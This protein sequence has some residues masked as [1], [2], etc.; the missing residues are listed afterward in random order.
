[1]KNLYS[2]ELAKS[3]YDAI[4]IGSGLGGLTTAVCLSKAGKKVLVLEK[5]YVPGGFTHTFK[6]KKYEWD[7]GVHYVGQVNIKNN[8]LCKAFDYLTEGKLKWADMGDVYDQTIIDGDT[9]NFK[10]GRKNQID[11]MI[12]YFPKEEKAIVAYY[13]LVEKIGANYIMFFS[14][15]TMPLWLSK[16]VGYFLR[17]KFYKYSQQTTYKILSNLTSNEK[18]IAV[19][20][21]QCGNYGLAPKQS[22]FAIH[23]MIVEHFLEGGNYPVGGASSIHKSLI[24]VI[25]S[26]GGKIAIKAE[27]KNIMIENN[28][29]IGVEMKN[30][31]KL[32]ASSIVS[33]AGAHNTFNTL[34]SKSIQKNENTTELNKIKPSVSHVCIYVGLNASD[35]E[36]KLPKHN[37]WI[38]DS[39][40]LDKTH[41][42]HLEISESVSPL[43]YIS[44]PSA[45]DPDWKIKHPGMSTIQVIGSYPYKWMKQWEDQQWQKRDTDYELK[46]EDIKNKLLEKLYA[47]V[48]QVKGRVEICELSTPLS[49]KHFSNYSNGEIYGLEHTPQRFNLR[50]L[51]AKTNYKNLFLTGQDVVCV[52]VGGALFSGIITSVSILKRNLLWKISRHKVAHNVILN[53]VKNL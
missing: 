49:T 23:G 12:E 41:N 36:L 32:Y 13:N 50:Q 21:A 53:G 9:Y 51:R 45:K 52:G 33:N 7:V 6:R 27:V 25:E 48:P 2:S 29:A 1:L 22:S 14:E 11:Q 24:D 34:I 20:C 18:L 19:L 42:D 30:G 47:T 16:T 40:Q 8:L 10:K 28:K 4:I 35:E 5:H 39:Y 26:H 46:K 37:I 44:F 17:R 31:D 15:R 3:K 38:Y 43:S